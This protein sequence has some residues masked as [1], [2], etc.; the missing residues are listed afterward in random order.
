MLILERFN[1]EEAGDDPEAWQAR[2]GVRA[3]GGGGSRRFTD[4]GWYG[5]KGMWGGWA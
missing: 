5:Q 2:R 1:A 3:A 4:G